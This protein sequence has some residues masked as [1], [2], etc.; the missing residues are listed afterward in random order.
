MRTAIAARGYQLSG[1]PLIE[2]NST[3]K[4]WLKLHDW[5]KRVQF[6]VKRIGLSLFLSDYLSRHLGF[7]EWQKLVK[8]RL[9]A[10]ETA[11]LK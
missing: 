11:Y 2:V 6:R 8:L 9:N 3:R 1:L 10:I 5:W 4:Q 7:K